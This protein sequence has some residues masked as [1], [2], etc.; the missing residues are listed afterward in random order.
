MR[1]VTNMCALDKKFTKEIQVAVCDYYKKNSN[2]NALL[3][4]KFGISLPSLYKILK[5]NN[6]LLY[7]KSLP[8]KFK[9]YVE[10]LGGSVLGNYVGMRRK[11]LVQCKNEHIWEAI[12][13][14]VIYNN[15]WCK[16]CS[17]VRHKS[18]EIVRKIFEA[19]FK[20]A[21]YSNHP[22]WLWNKKTNKRLELDGYNEKLGI[23]FEYQGLQHYRNINSKMARTHALSYIQKNDRRK[24]LLC[25]RNGVKLV[26][27]RYFNKKA[28]CE[29]KIDQVVKRIK[30]CVGYIPNVKLI[31]E[32]IFSA[33]NLYDA[34]SLAEK[35][36]EKQNLVFLGVKEGNGFK[37]CWITSF[38]RYWYK[39]N[40]CDH[41]WDRIGQSTKKYG[42]PICGR[43]NNPQTFKKNPNICD[44]IDA[45]IIVQELGIKSISEYRIRYKE[46]IHL[47]SCP[48]KRYKDQWKS[49]RYFLGKVNV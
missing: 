49:Y 22:P 18:E 38:T 6:V 17:N 47:P 20:T 36:A 37:K 43:A 46:S 8:L 19:I 39:C 30:K 13:G 42:C 10:Y 11:V 24:A 44:M 7:K 29:Q 12:P 40:K 21:F 35:D 15:K 14:N 26:T 41:I 1:A 27:V 2:K 32:K 23:A 34:I 48:H 16:R 28:T 3:C 45:M 4:K 33:Y 25:N 5:V 9:K 31:P